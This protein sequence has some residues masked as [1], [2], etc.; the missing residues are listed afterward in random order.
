MKRA[1]G[2]IA[3]GS[4]CILGKRGAVE[5]RQPVAR[6][7]IQ[8]Q[9]ST[10]VIRQIEAEIVNAIGKA[11]HQ[12][13]V[14]IRM[15]RDRKA[16]AAARYAGDGPSF[17]KPLSAFCEPVKWEPPIIAGDDIMRKI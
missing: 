1:P 4:Q 5:V 8:I 11:A 9:T 16:G 2:C 12:R 17:E 3:W 13:I 7:P 10:A 6:I 15:K 14:A